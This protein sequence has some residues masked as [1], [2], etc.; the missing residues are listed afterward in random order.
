[1]AHRRQLIA[2]LTRC[3]T[4]CIA[5]ARGNIRFFLAC[6]CTS[7]VFAHHFSSL[8]ARSSDRAPHCARGAASGLPALGIP[9]PQPVWLLE[10]DELVHIDSLRIMDRA[11]RVG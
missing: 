11:A 1:M 3:T 7:S 4:S 10:I 5:A 8:A 2:C 6:S 9:P